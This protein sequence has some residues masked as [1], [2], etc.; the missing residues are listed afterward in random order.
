MLVRR[1]KTRKEEDEE[2]WGIGCHASRENRREEQGSPVLQLTKDL[3][4]IS[5]C[6]VAGPGAASW[7]PVIRLELPVIRLEILVGLAA[8]CLSPCLSS[9][10]VPISACRTETRWRDGEEEEEEEEED[11][12]EEEREDETMGTPTMPAV[13]TTAELDTT[14]SPE[15]A[16][17]PRPNTAESAGTVLMRSEDW[18]RIDLTVGWSGSGI[19]CSWSSIDALYVVAESTASLQRIF[20]KIA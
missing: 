4:G 19:G 15:G 18:G 8:I 1:V 10:L 2:E 6:T 14:D 5:L 12:E 13:T 3:H 7:L 9:S 16:E 11:E 17:D 20:R